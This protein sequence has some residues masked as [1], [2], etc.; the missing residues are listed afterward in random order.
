M[1][2]GGATMPLDPQIAGWGRFLV[3]GILATMA[4]ATLLEGSQG[5][6]ISRLSL[7]FMVGTM[8]SPRRRPAMAAGFVIYLL[9]GLVFSGFYW[10]V[11][12]V[13]GVGTWWLG[14]LLGL[15]HG[16][17]LL[18]VVLPLLPFVHPRMAAE[19][20]G[21][22]RAH[23]IEPPGFLALNYGFATPLTTLAAQAVYG[24]ILG[25]LYPG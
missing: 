23:G 17:F 4:L 14:G 2:A 13:L 24:I 3:A 10:L 8:F 1:R 19:H 12:A 5:L 18:T 11:F 7:P 16:L 25:S 6:R 22:T 9:G 20:D 21:P 15:G